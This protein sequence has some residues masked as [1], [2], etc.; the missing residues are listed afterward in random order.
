MARLDP[1][2]GE[3]PDPKVKWRSNYRYMIKTTSQIESRKSYIKGL[4]A[5][6]M[7]M[8]EEVTDEEFHQMALGKKEL[9]R[10]DTYKVLGIEEI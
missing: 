2:K 7:Y 1:R 8:E 9:P 10:L 3:Y 5:Q 6:A 4:K